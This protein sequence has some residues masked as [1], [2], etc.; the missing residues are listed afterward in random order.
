MINSS[1]EEWFQIADNLPVHIIYGRRKEQQ[2]YNYPPVISNLG[3][4]VLH[5]VKVRYLY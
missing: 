1:A 4:V 2:G 5:N 3:F